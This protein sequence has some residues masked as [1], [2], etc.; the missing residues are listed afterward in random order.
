MSCASPAVQLKLQPYLLAYLRVG[1]PDIL[2]YVQDA[3][4][5]YNFLYNLQ[6]QQIVL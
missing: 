3:Y 1:L 4:D 2:A 6:L 5:N